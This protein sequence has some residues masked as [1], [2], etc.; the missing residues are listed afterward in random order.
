M[1]EIE[2]ELTYLAK[3]LPANLAA[4]PLTLITDIYYPDNVPEPQLRLRQKGKRYEIT[5]KIM[6]NDNDSSHMIEET[7]PL[8]A[9]EF[10]ALTKAGGK[11]VTKR[12]YIYDYQGHVAEIDVFQQGLKGLVLVDFE[13]T[14]RTDQQNFSLPDFCLADVTQELFVAGHQLIGKSYADIAPDLARF[15]YKPL[16]VTHA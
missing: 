5:K 9:Q 15:N 12:R 16:E 14:N 3:S 8:N 10:A 4:C 11:R 6:A 1:T 13:F 7:I 2:L